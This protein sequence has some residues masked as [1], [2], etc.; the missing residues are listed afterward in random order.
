M[1]AVAT[2]SAPAGTTTPPPVGGPRPW[3]CTPAEFDKL[4]EAGFFLERRYQLIR[5]EVIDMG[6]Q[7]SRHF[8]MVDLAV[9]VLKAAFGPG[10]FVRNA[11]PI[12][13]SDSKPEPDVSVVP[14]TR[15]DYVIDH[16]A[17]ALLAVEVSLTTLNYDLTTKA[18][19]YATAGIR[20]YWVL[21][22]DGKQLH[23]FRDPGQLPTALEASAYA[24]HL[25]Y[26][27]GDSVQP[28][29]APNAVN[30]SDLLP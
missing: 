22:L 26:S 14:G 11:G 1:S 10:F 30:V 17:T 25:T 20:E 16:P 5:G 28:L 2:P 12:R 7:S 9:E 4:T 18:E 29:S 19:L 27:P 21:D 3:R 8:T 23:V 6:E 24:T 15:F 13:L